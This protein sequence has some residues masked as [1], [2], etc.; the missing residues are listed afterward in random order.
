[1]T[2][3]TL[4]ANIAAGRQVDD[5]VQRFHSIAGQFPCPACQKG[6]VH[7][8][9]SHELKTYTYTCDA[10]CG[11]RGNGLLT[12]DGGRGNPGIDP[13]PAS[14]GEVGFQFTRPEGNRQRNGWRSI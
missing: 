14:A 8:S 3:D 4:R 7:W 13:L 10:G 5:T 2:P 9:R 6:A 12:P 1:M 11:V